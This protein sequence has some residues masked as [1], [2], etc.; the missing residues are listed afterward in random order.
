MMRD[1][2]LLI[3]KVVPQVGQELNSDWRT[4]TLAQHPRAIGRKTPAEEVAP[5]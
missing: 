5:L 4:K 3:E 1:M 2:F